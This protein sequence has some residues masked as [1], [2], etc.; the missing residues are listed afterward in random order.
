MA[1]IVFIPIGTLY[2]G[3][4]TV[5]TLIIISSILIGFSGVFLLSTLSFDKIIDQR[6]KEIMIEET[7]DVMP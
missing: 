1:S 4:I 5:E 6:K 7:I 2:F 3:T